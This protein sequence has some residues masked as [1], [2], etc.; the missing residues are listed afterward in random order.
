M[1]ISTAELSLLVA[2]L[3]G[4]FT[5]AAA[6]STQH[7]QG[8]RQRDLAQDDRIWSTRAET[9]VELLK[10]QGAGMVEG[11]IESATQPEW[12]V[13]DELTAKASAFASAEVWDLW[14]R[15]ARASLA[16]NQYAEEEWPQ[17]MVEDAPPYAFGEAIASDPELRRLRQAIDDAGRELARQIRVELDFS[18]RK[19]RWYQ[20]KRRDQYSLPAPPKGTPPTS[21][22]P[23]GQKSVT[24]PPETPGQPE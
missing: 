11:D 7:I 16:L 20:L 14:Q 2:G 22:P 12:S 18:R 4:T 15:S 6:L 10:F 21:L 5:L 9:Y 24:K 3:T 1:L 19:R 13:R 23:A 17:L 8:R